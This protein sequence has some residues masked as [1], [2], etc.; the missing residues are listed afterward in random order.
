MLITAKFPSWCPECHKPIAVGHKIEWQKGSKAKHPECIK[1][2]PTEEAAISKAAVLESRAET[3]DIEIP[4]PAGL[5]Y[6]NFQKAGISYISKRPSVL[7]ADEMGLGKS[8]EVLGVINLDPNIHRVLMVVPASLKINWLLEATK[9][10]ARKLTVKI[11]DIPEDLKDVPATDYILVTN[12]DRLVKAKGEL[13]CQALVSK[14]FDMFVGDECHF[15]KNPKASRT[16]AVL[17]DKKGNKGLI[18]SAKRKVL[19]TGTPLPNRPVEMFPVLSALDPITFGNFF[20]FA[21]T[22]CNAHQETIYIPGGYGETKEVWDFSG[23]SNLEQLQQVLRSSVMLRRLKADVL[24]ELPSKTRQVIV[25]PQTAETKKA[26]AEERKAFAEHEKKVEA[27]RLLMEQAKALNNKEAYAAAAYNLKDAENVAFTEMSRVR[28]N[29]AVAKIPQAIEHIT[30]VLESVGKVVCFFHH[31]DVGA[32]FKEH[33]G[34]SAV[35]LT[36]DT[37]QVLRQAA[38]DRFQKDASCT[39]FLGSITASGVGITLTAASTEVF[40]EMDWVPANITQCE[41]RCHRIGQ[42]NA[43]LVQHLV[44]DDSLDARMIQTV[45]KKQ[46]IA[47][48]ALDK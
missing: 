13:M 29:T 36:G 20:S 15:L 27:L 9:W 10:L 3:S 41:D 32:A 21:K 40:C 38:V 30:D 12:Y 6:L 43:V 14:G 5:S 16:K 17:G 34:D 48:A 35:M 28:H 24:K 45:L 22:Y 25:L 8:I 23:A 42:K 4:C 33:F 37:P 2:A 19:L 44:I 46:A 31:K 18:H 11:V 7:L 47:D 1:A 39:L 26:V